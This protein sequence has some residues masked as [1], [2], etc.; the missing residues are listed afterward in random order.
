[1][2]IKVGVDYYKYALITVEAII[3]GLAMNKNILKLKY[4]A[5]INS[6]YTTAYVPDK[7]L[8]FE[9]LIIRQGFETI[10]ECLLNAVEFIREGDKNE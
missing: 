8:P 5:T 2:Q 9:E 1:M 4:C 3:D 10:E 6:L 7:Q